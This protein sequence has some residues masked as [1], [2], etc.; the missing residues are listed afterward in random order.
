MSIRTQA[1]CVDARDPSALA[2]FWSQVLGLRLTYE[3]P[4]EAVLEPP[5]GSPE[6][7]S[8]RSSRLHRRRP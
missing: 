7:G 5:A 3:E 4:G 1:A 2:R 6:D 8:R